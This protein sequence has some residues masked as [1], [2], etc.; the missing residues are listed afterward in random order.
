[1]NVLTHGFLC[2]IADTTSVNLS[3]AELVFVAN[4]SLCSQVMVAHMCLKK[5]L[6]FFPFEWEAHLKCNL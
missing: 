4:L 5:K 1:M 3:I 2:S 6:P